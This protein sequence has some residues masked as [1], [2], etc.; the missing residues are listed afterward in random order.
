MKQCA[1]DGVKEQ[2]V[3]CKGDG[4]LGKKL[5][6]Y[7]D[8]VSACVCVFCSN[9]TDFKRC[10]RNFKKQLIQFQIKLMRL[11]LVVLSSQVKYQT[12]SRWDAANP[13]WDPRWEWW[14]P[15]FGSG[16]PPF[17]SGM[18]IISHPGSRIKCG[19]SASHPGSQVGF[20][21]PTR[22][23]MQYLYIPH[24]ILGGNCA[25]H[26]RS[27]SGLAYPTWDT[28]SHL[29]AYTSTQELEKNPCREVVC[30]LHKK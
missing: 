10:P 9:L 20:L 7:K 22:D 12:G 4:V 21:S 30:T 1:R 24:G 14:D 17:P 13:T 8:R 2:C 23:F 26:L 28:L 5:N 16:I 19:I 15:A 11:H 18:K 27:Q 25:S 29:G 3:V 6:N